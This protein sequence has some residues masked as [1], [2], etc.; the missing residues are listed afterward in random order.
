MTTTECT[1]TP[2]ECRDQCFALPVNHDDCIALLAALATIRQEVSDN[3]WNLRGW[4]DNT[5]T[6]VEEAERIADMERFIAH[7]QTL[8]ARIVDVLGR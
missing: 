2:T 6:T 7:Y 5:G 4:C 8:S 3:L 1:T